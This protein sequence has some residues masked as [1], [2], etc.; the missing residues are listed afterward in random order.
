MN[1]YDAVFCVLTYKN[2]KDL[3]EFISS[4]K[5]ACGFSYKIVVVNS[6]YDKE[7]E[8]KI[9]A[10]ATEGNCDF[11]SVENK[12][13]GA[14]NNRGIDFARENYDFD[15]LIVCNP[16]TVIKKFDLKDLKDVKDEYFIAGPK[17][18]CRKRKNQ[19]PAVAKNSKLANALIYKGFSKDRKLFIYAGYAVNKLMKLF[20]FYYLIK[21][22]TL[23]QAHGSFVIF[24][25]NT[26]DKLLPVYDENVFLFSEEMDLGYKTKSLK[27]KSYY[28]PKIRV[29]HK[30]DGSV[31][32]SDLNVYAESKKS[33]IYVMDKWKTKKGK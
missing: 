28:L 25:K 9:N 7:S 31:K 1:F 13:Y 16:D 6:F 32:L 14:G 30:E 2:E 5:D 18:I 20:S 24:P 19:N 27:I 8:E 33:L 3:K 26:L 4:A 17:I 12:G 10:V 29:Y 21:T 15:Y 11:I 22:P 23:F